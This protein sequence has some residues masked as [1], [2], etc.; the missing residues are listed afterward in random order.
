LIATDLSR[1][2]WNGIADLVRRN[3]GHREIYF[4]RVIRSDQGKNL[5]WVK[6]LGDRAIP[7]VAHHYSFSYY[8]TVPTGNV[9]EGQPVNTVKQ[10]REDKTNTNTNFRT[11]II[12]PK[13]GQIA[14]I[15]DPWG[16][17][18]F[19]ICIG[20]IQSSTGYWEGE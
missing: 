12:C 1:A 20:M 16:A 4:A 18:R 3:K 19:P 9:T 7:L 17:R 14:V 10:K 5:I 15:L 11:K 13:K 2:I 8:D 6:E